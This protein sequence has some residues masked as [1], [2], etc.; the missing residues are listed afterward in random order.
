MKT[1]KL[2]NLKKLETYFNKKN[3]QSDEEISD[4]EEVQD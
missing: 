4:S 2:K 3:D 1:K